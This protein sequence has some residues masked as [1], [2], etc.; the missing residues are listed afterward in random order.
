[1]PYGGV[2]CS[3]TPT[4]LVA[5]ATASFHFLPGG[6]DAVDPGDLAALPHSC[7][8]VLDQDAL[9]LHPGERRSYEA[10]WNG[11]LSRERCSSVDDSRTCA[12]VALPPASGVWTVRV[13]ASTSDGT[14]TYGWSVTTRI[15]WS[16]AGAATG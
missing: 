13:E 11:S 8:P 12:P 10:T 15:D 16:D 9:A 14:A 2:A 7:P 1:M 6:S 5:N 4:F 3:T